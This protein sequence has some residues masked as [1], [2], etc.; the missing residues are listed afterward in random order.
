MLPAHQS[1]L[2]KVRR[3]ESIPSS[4]PPPTAL[5]GVA[6]QVPSNAVRNTYATRKSSST[7]M[8]TRSSSTPGN[9][10]VAFRAASTR[11]VKNVV[12]SAILAVAM[13]TSPRLLCWA[14]IVLYLAWIRDFRSLDKHG[15][16]RERCNVSARSLQVL[17]R[18]A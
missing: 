2:A 12:V 8:A 9:L 11:A 6:Y 15:E 16:T 3:L 1:S 13:V 18:H 5:F 4:I 17:I 14:A 10:R 7:A